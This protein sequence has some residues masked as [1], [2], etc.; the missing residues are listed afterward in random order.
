MELP[1]PPEP[2]QKPY[3]S[4]AVAIASF[5]A[6]KAHR[7]VDV[8]PKARLILGR[9]NG[10]MECRGKT[11][12]NEITFSDLVDFRAGWAD[13][14]ATQRRNQELLKAFFRFALRADFVAKNPA[15]DL[16]PIKE[17][18]PKTEPFSHSNLRRFLGLPRLWVTNMA[19]AAN[20]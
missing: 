3:T 1:N 13:A 15:L 14:A 10:F 19:G 2:S 8:Q 17:V 5:L 6:F 18:R 20:R 7:S 9:L 4:M 11:T 16:D 12:I